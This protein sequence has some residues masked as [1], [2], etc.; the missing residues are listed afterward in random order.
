MNKMQRKSNR[1]AFLLEFALVSTFI[2]IPL[3]LGTMT[4]GMTLVRTIHVYQLNR[5]AGHM[6]ARGV[7]FSQ[8]QNRA[9]LI[10]MS[11]GLNITDSGGNGVIILSLI[12]AVNAGQAVCTRQLVIGN[13]GLRPS[14]FTNPT[15]VDSSGNVTIAGDPGA[16]ANS[17]LNVMAMAPGDTAYVAESYFSSSDY[18][19]T[20]F[21]TGNG[22]YTRAVF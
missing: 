18:D 1:G 14:S 21:L 22:T 12:Q 4:V 17:F 2:L 9:L 15:L 3:I 20:G 16:V 13:A 7:D 19:W 5:D 10:Q 6:F 11:A 8:A